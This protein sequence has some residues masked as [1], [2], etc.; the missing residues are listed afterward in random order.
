MTHIL[1]SYL[2][3]F[4]NTGFHTDSTK[5]TIVLRFVAIRGHE[6]H[7]CKGVCQFA[8]RNADISFVTLLRNGGQLWTWTKTTLQPTHTQ[9]IHYLSSISWNSY[10]S[11]CSWEE[12]KQWISLNKGKGQGGLLNMCFAQLVQSRVKSS[13]E[14]SPTVLFTGAVKIKRPYGL[15]QL[16]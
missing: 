8:F 7:L 16:N 14:A 5:Q 3:K 2:L 4:F 6:K 15:T 1:T 11:V 12:F 13:V 9:I 10:D